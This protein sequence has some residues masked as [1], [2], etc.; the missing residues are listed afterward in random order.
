MSAL[1]DKSEINIDAAELLNKNNK[2]CSVCHPAYYACLQMMEYK[3]IRKGK[4]LKLQATEISQYYKGHSHKYLIEETKKLIRFDK[5]REE[6]NYSNSIKQ[7]KEY[8]EI[9][10]YHDVNITHD[11][12]TKAIQLAKELLVKINS[13]RI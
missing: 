2:Y 4:S 1:C 9:S 3:L 6:Q 10:D 11:E 7:L 12:S 5:F 13:I 8:R